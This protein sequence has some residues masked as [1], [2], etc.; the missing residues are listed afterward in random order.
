MTLT[1]RPQVVTFIRFLE[2]NS[3]AL[4]PDG[5][6][7]EGSGL[8]QLPEV[9]VQDLQTTVSVPDG[10]TLLLGGQK[11]ANEVDREQ[12]VPILSK[13]PILNRGFTNRGFARDESTLLILIKP[14]IIIQR[15]EEE[16]QVP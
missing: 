13:I 14:K 5:E 6:P 4:G 12:G 1:V 9:Q 11:I 7:L 15:E 2:Y 3:N 10:G 8:I 16:R